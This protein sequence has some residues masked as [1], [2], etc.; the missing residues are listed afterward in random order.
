M[1]DISTLTHLDVELVE[2][3]EL[4]EQREMQR[5]A[6]QYAAATRSGL[7]MAFVTALCDRESRKS[8]HPDHLEARRVLA[9]AICRYK[10]AGG[11]TVEN[12][13]AHLL[14]PGEAAELSRRPDVMVRLSVQDYAGAVASW[15]ANPFPLNRA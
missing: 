4:I 10:G 7:S 13:Y 8:L 5:L 9:R 6:K 3:I 14:A 11:K 12:H 2:K 1:T 15:H